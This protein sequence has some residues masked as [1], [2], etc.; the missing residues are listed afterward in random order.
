[1]NTCDFPLVFLEK[2]TSAGLSEYAPPVAQLMQRFFLD[3]KVTLEIE[4][5]M[6]MDKLGVV[7]AVCTWMKAPENI[8]IWEAWLPPRRFWVECELGEIVTEAGACAACTPGFHSK[9]PYATECVACKPGS[10]NCCDKVRWQ[11]HVEAGVLQIAGHFSPEAG[12]T[13]CVSCDVLGDFY[14]ELAGQQSCLRCPTNT[15]R[16]TGVLDGST[17]LACMCK[18]GAS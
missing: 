3:E 12:R 1:M 18:E 15:I 4:G 10:L 14:Q 11:L 2:A 17:H 8:P 9:E 5:R 16:Y 7:G 6:E 13:D